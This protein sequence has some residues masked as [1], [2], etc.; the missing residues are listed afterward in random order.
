MRLPILDRILLPDYININIS[1]SEEVVE[2]VHQQCTHQHEGHVVREGGHLLCRCSGKQWPAND[3]PAGSCKVAADRDTQPVCLTS[4]SLHAARGCGLRRAGHPGM[5]WAAVP[6]RPAGGWLLCGRIRVHVRLP[7]PSCCL[8]ICF[9][10][11]A[12]DL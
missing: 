10:T 5:L 6:A 3:W 2:D 11:R 7:A 8:A 12:G 1:E 4:V 9:I